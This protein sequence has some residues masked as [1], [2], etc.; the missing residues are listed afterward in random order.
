MS[1][2]GVYLQ[3]TAWK[4]SNAREGSLCVLEMPG[5][6]LTPSQGLAFG[7]HFLFSFV[8]LKLLFFLAVCY[9]LLFVC[10]SL[11]NLQCWLS[12]KYL[13]VS[14]VYLKGAR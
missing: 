5:P 2:Y 14:A 3:E 9:I 8:L 12:P 10:W 13:T 4:N 6:I 11:E 1:G 7:L